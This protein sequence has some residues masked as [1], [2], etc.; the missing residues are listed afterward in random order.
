[1]SVKVLDSAAIV[2]FLPP[3]SRYE[4]P[5][6]MDEP[7]IRVAV[8]QEGKWSGKWSYSGTLE[9]QETKIQF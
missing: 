1:M 9:G 3:S 6:D 8:A 4:L 2:P 7:L 5:A